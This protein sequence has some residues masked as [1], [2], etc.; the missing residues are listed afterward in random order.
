MAQD[1]R[2]ALRKAIDSLVKSYAHHEK[3][4]CQVDFGIIDSDEISDLCISNL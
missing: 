4:G 1:A 3:W 2:V